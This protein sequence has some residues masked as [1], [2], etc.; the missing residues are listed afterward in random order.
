[1]LSVTYADC[2][3]KALYAKCRYAECRCAECRGAA[4]IVVMQLKLAKSQ[5]T[6]REKLLI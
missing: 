1:M 3:I 5:L 4:E 6:C 2:N